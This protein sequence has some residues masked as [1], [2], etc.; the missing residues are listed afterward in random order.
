LIWKFDFSPF[1]TL[2]IAIL[3]DGTILTISKDRVKPSPHPDSWKLAEIFFTGLCIGIYLAVFTVIF[4]WLA[5]R[6]TFFQDS[7]G[8]DDIRNNYYKLN[9]ALYL[10]VSIISQALIFVT[11]SQSFSYFERP[12]LLL[13]GAFCVAQLIATF[14]A[15]YAEWGFADINGIGWGWA[16]VIWLYDL[17]WYLPLDLIKF[18]VRYSLS[19][20]MWALIFNQSTTLANKPNFGAD[21]R[22]AAWATAQ[23]SLHGLPVA[24]T[25]ASPG[26]ANPLTSTTVAGTSGSAAES[27]AKRAEIAKLRDAT[28]LK[29]HMES[30]VKAKNMDVDTIKS[31]YTV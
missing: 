3:N 8:V 30:V 28:T 5:H 11:R 17:I 13:M 24:G 10:Q 27:A 26:T 29:G 21:E 19:G 9:A 31:S 4:F 6:T 7:F 15:V 2:I 16:G 1:M 22:K 18:A 23:R 12:G 20:N 14:L 25:T